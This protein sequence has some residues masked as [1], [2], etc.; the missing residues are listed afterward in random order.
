MGSLAEHFLYGLPFS[1]IYRLSKNIPPYVLNPSFPE[2]PVTIG[3]VIRKLRIEH[4][5]FQKE[6]A[7]GIGVDEMTIVSWEK[8]R[9][10][11]NKRYMQR[12]ADCF[13][14]HPDDLK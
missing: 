4:G 5:L 8:S 11:P 13:L 7:K 1:P 14:I 3:D 6:L 9:T 10:I 12:I 2:N